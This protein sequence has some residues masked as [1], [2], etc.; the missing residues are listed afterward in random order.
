VSATLR[1]GTLGG[2]TDV[3]VVGSGAAGLTSALAALEAGATVTVLEKADVLGGTTALSGGMLWLPC[4]PLAA[5]GGFGD[6]P[7]RALTYMR[8][9]TQGRASDEMLQAHI[10]RGADLLEFVAEEAGLHF[11]L[12]GSFPDYHPELDGGAVGGRS[13]EPELYNLKG[14]GALRDAVRFDP[15][16]PFQQREYFEEW[17]TYRNFP[18]DE[19]A[20]RRREGIVSRGLALVAPLVKAIADRGAA[21]VTSARVERLLVEDGRVVGVMSADGEVRASAVI[22]ASGGFEW[23]ADL[24]QRFLSGPVE[25]RCS[26]PSN[27]GD[28]LRMAMAAGVDLANMSEAWWAVHAR[29]PGLVADGQNLAT[30]VTVERSL[31]GSFVVNTRGERFTN[32]SGSY[33]AFGKVLAA[34]DAE[35]YGYRNLPAFL[36]ADA[37]YFRRY[38]ILGADDLGDLPPW[39]TAADSVPELAAQL[40]VDRDGLV[41]TV[42]R[43]NRHATAGT[44]PDFGRGES[45][46]DRYFGDP[47]MPH[48]NLAPLVD[49]PF[50]ALRL[51]C[52][53]IGTKGGVRTDVNGQALDPFDRPV[54]GLFAAGNVA[55]H[56]VAF[57]YFG[58]GSTIGPGMTMALAAGRAAATSA[59]RV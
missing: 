16:E 45:A 42:E 44:D 13:V 25:S 10:D 3:V 47:S 56:P 57:G 54:C 24:C 22:L 4:N 33:Y 34:F 32:E 5:A 2:P 38:G 18:W 35:R 21:L 52:G 29:I 43:F 59:S 9:I 7:E 49:A 15:R 30:I 36:I 46:Y 58:A 1:A 20:K 17:H 31:P 50:V 6:T 27:V 51:E 28:G 48:A 40:G 12:I 39:L 14:L 26:A 55:A 37:A 8:A 23:N 11:T 19:L 53:A 41:A